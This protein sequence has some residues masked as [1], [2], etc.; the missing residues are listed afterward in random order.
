M[1]NNLALEPVARL[2]T[3]YVLVVVATIAALALLAAAAPSQATGDAWVHAAIVTVFAVLLP[4]RLRA[5]RR[6]DRRAAAAVTVVATVLMVVNV[7]EAAIPGLFPVWM[8]IEMIGIAVLM[9]AIVTASL[10]ARR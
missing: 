8:R 3:V 2:V 6:G 1:A 7:V 9:A 10:R 4:I 5:A